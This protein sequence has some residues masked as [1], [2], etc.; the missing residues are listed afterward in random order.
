MK[1]VFIEA[2]SRMCFFFFGG[3]ESGILQNVILRQRDHFL[4]LSRALTF[5]A[6]K[7]FGKNDLVILDFISIRN[8]IFAFRASYIYGSNASKTSQ[9]S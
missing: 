1:R 6:V 4:A 8:V 7:V 9:S 2:N 5:T 3:R